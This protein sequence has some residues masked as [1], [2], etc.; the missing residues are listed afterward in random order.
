MYKKNKLSSCIQLAL[1]LGVLSA[2]VSVAFAQQTENEE[3]TQ[4]TQQE[5]QTAEKEV[6]E[7]IEV[8][9]SRIKRTDLEPTQPMTVVDGEYFSERGLTNA[10]DA[11]VEIPGVQ[12]AAS[13]VIGANV[14]ASSQGVGQNTIN[15][16][17]LGSQRT[18]TLVNGHRFVS[19]NSPVGGGSAPGSQ[20]DVNNIPISLIERVEVVKV[21]GA[22]VYG[23]DAVAGV[24]NYVLKKDYEG[25]EV[26][27][28]Y[29]DKDGIANE[30][31]FRTLLGGNFGGGRGNVVL[32]VEYNETDN[33]L[34]SEVPSLRDSWTLQQPSAADRVLDPDGNFNPGQ[35]RLY[36]QPRAGIL[37]FSGLVTPGPL[38]VTNFGIGQWGDGNFYQFA[39]D[40]SG[41]LVGYD[42][43]VATGN[44]VWSSGGDGLDLVATNTAQEGYERVNITAIAN[45]E[46]T[47]DV[48]FSLTT[49]ANSS[50]AAN[51]GYQ[52]TLYSS[53]VFGG[54]GAALR[55]STDNP[56]LTDGSRNELENLLDGPG[57]FYMHR[58]W[59]NLGQREVVN[60]SNVRSIRFG[61]DGEFDIAN[62]YFDW[63]VSYQRGVSSVFSQSTAINDWRWLTAMDVGINPETGQVDCKFNYVD[64]YGDEL[65]PQGS[66]VRGT[67]SILGRPGDCSPFNPFGTASEASIDYISYLSMGKTRVEQDILSAYISGDLFY[68]PSGT[69]SAL[70]GFE[71]RREYADFKSDG[72]DQFMG[73]SDNSTGGEYRT[74]D[75][76]GELY[77]PLADPSQ[78]IPLVYSASLETS[79]RR[80]DNSRSGT[81]NAWAVGVNYR[82]I[83]DLIIRAN[84][85]ETVRSPAITE[86][87]LPR[88]QIS[89][90]A[91]DPCHGANRGNGPDP[92][93]RQRN[94]DA[95]GIPEDFVSIAT[96]AS[97]FGYTGGN[98]NLSNEQAE[99]KNIGIVYAPSW[100]QGLDLSVDWVEI[101]IEDAI[102]SFSLTN[103]M[104]ACY[105]ATNYPN[106]FCDMFVRGPDFQLPTIDAF[107]SGYV[108]AALR[109]FEAIEYTGRYH[110]ALHEFPLVGGWFSEGMGD[111]TMTLRM[112]NLKK[113][114]T[115]N[116]GFDFSD[117]TG[118]Y[119]NP[120]WRGDF[121]IAHRLD[122]LLTFLDV[123]YSGEGSRNVNNTD[124]YKYIDIDG[125]PYNSLPSI[126]TFDLG[127]V[128]DFSDTVRFRAKV[129]N[130][131]DWYPGRK[132]LQAG[133][134][135]W[136]RTYS[137]GLN[138]KF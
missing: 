72:T 55:F 75:V 7:R 120:D 89:S 81:D 11:V 25:A 138:M 95:E 85:A 102:T 70:V 6:V 34:S 122:R 90:F 104:E 62:R 86:L 56:F 116:T 37:S 129:E 28:D 10:A 5:E 111:L 20:V 38:A 36:P 60:E 134:W 49:F 59:L 126:T 92:E 118:Q 123:R 79:Y 133:R 18:L 63:E 71:S 54:T 78:D 136:G 128:Y 109:S 110:K 3:N 41:A 82:P 80:M 98:P 115:S 30:V 103:I 101:D 94:C 64:G 47:D 46:L 114:A 27:V 117:S 16:F 15:I 100:A 35:L 131:G 107:E 48:N 22:A 29:E 83:E 51:P 24:V 2:P 130:V 13:P 52:A 87:F 45:Y 61:F 68:L 74:K 9:G 127:V 19:S 88:V 50:D 31:S 77:I 53:G 43:G 1:A 42:P 39:M 12:A 112:Y 67:E 57:D 8:T 106:Q 58:G 132:E 40:G 65:V 44:A 119:N 14:G 125:T 108:N 137:V 121:K 135:T 76:F 17:G 73:F 66:G 23:S 97:R 99:S 105:D 113:N 21:G 69:V 26:S 4:N 32:S 96:N 93:T 91:A 84:V 124:E 33:V